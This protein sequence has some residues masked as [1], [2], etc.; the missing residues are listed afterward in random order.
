MRPIILLFLVGIV[1]ATEG[2]PAEIQSIADTVLKDQLVCLGVQ[3]S[4]GSS[5]HRKL[6]HIRVGVP[7]Q[8]HPLDVSLIVKDSSNLSVT[9]KI[10]PGIGWAIPL[11]ENNVP[12][13]LV[14]VVRNKVGNW[15]IQGVGAH[16]FALAWGIINGIWKGHQIIL[17][18]AP[19]CAYFFIPDKGDS[20]LTV[21]IPVGRKEQNALEPNEAT[22]YYSKLTPS[23]TI[24]KAIRERAAKAENCKDSNRLVE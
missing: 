7:F 2:V 4:S 10:R 8:S 23:S 11:I 16:E 6:K 18:S 9:N 14:S 13:L 21:I 15:K 24:F 17:C 12:F 20:N 19:A 22:L 1:N 5:Q 3:T